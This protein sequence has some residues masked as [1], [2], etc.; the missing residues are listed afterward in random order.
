VLE[1]Y[2]VL[3]FKWNDASKKRAELLKIIGRTPLFGVILM[4][5]KSLHTGSAL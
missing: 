3:I 2:G 1:D 4:E 5:V